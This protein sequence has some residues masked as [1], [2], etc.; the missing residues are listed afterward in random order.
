[1]TILVDGS[2]L[3]TRLEVSQS[4]SELMNSVQSSAHC[5]KYLTWMPSIW[6]LVTLAAAVRIEPSRNNQRVSSS[7]REFQ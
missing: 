1:L 4:L 2:N 6:L 3:G 5:V 7:N